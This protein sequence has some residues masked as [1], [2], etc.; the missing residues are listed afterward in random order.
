MDVKAMIEKMSLEE[1]AS[2]LSGRDFWHTDEV[3]D[4]G[5]SSFMMCDGPNGLRKQI[6]KE[7]HLEYQ[8]SMLSYFKCCCCFI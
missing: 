6:G 4:A 7:D 1:K 2:Y 5:V 3:L 8:N